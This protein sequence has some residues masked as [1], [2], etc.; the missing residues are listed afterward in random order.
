MARWTLYAAHAIP[1]LGLE[2][3]AA[4]EN[5]CLPRGISAKEP[6]SRGHYAAGPKGREAWGLGEGESGSAEMLCCLL[7]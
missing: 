7:V 4:D 2:H 1:L 6:W 5:S 3:M